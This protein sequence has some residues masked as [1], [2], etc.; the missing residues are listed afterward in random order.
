MRKLDIPFAC[1]AVLA[2][3]LLAAPVRGQT[4]EAA[5]VGARRAR[6][7]KEEEEEDKGEEGKGEEGKDDRWR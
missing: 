3:T 1:A 5:A 4:P 2:L 7:E 6:Q